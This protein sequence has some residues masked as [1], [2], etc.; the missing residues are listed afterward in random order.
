MFGN[1]NLAGRFTHSVFGDAISTPNRYKWRRGS[2]GLCQAERSHHWGH[3]PVG[4]VQSCHLELVL[5]LDCKQT[6]LL[7]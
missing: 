2:R 3:R 4:V 7:S 6:S 5:S 1:I